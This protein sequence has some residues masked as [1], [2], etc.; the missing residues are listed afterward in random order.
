MAEWLIL[1]LLVPAIVVPAVLLL[2]FAGCNT[3]F[4]VHDTHLKPPIPVI[5]SAVGKGVS[6]ITLTWHY[7]GPAQRFLIDRTKVKDGTKFSFEAPASPFDD[8]GHNSSADPG[9]EPGTDYSYVVTAR[10]GDG[11]LSDPS[12]PATGTTTSFQTAFDRT[13]K[14]VQDGTGWAGFTLV[15]RIEPAALTASG[16]P[17]PLGQVKITLRTSST[18]GASIDRIYISQA[19]PALGANPYDS[20]AA[21][22]AA[23][24]D[25]TPFP[26]APTPLIVGTNTSLTLPRVTDPVVIYT[27]DQTKPLLIA[28]DF[29]ASPASAIA[30]EDAAA[31]T[32][33]DPVQ[34]Y[35]SNSPGG[36][37]FKPKRVGSYTTPP[38]GRRLYLIEKI[39]AG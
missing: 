19:D 3:V 17:P 37:A 35:Y 29:S 13:G 26:Q 8:A 4:G 22:L 36:E 20:L 10:S 9:L 23:V 15:Q 11:S 28:I 24:Y 16:Q 39:E 25:P 32:P 12:S 38:T 1:L 14:L 33:P 30:F 6:L 18:S 7:D 5:D 34:A 31:A 2:G 27:V 21:D